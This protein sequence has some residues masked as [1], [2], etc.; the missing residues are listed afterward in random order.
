M[1]LGILREN[2]KTLRLS[3][4]VKEECTLPLLFGT[5][6]VPLS[7][8]DRSSESGVQRIRELGLGALE[9]EFVQG[10]RMGAEKAAQV[11]EKAAQENVVLSCHGPF[12]I[13]LNS[14][15]PEKIAASKERILQA[16]RIGH[17]LGVTG[18]VFHPA[19][20]HDDEPIIVLRRV[21]QE[22][23]E[24]RDILDAEGNTVLLYPET[25][26]KPSQFG[27]VDETVILSQ[28]ISGVLPCL[29]FSHLYARSNGA[30][31]SYDAF[32]SVIERTAEALGDPW[33][34][35]AHCHVSGIEY[36]AKGEKRHLVLRDSGLAY[37]DLLQAL[38]TF[39]IEGIVV[40]E[41]PNLEEDALLLRETYAQT[42]P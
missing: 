2:D 34:H 31:N 19:F 11:A 30:V 28:Q 7:A 12:Y 9:I 1:K 6:G 37:Q 18:V 21:L 5:A 26:G 23:A 38:R 25:T 36:G 3:H 33:V 35:Q 24:V 16:A 27:T 4:G 40:C 41:S 32:C 10:V 15:E 14:R 39:G 17:I 42:I 8:T 29:D 22:L 20:Y 13:N